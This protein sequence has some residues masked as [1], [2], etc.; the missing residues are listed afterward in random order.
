MNISHLYRDGDSRWLI[1]TNEEH[2]AG[3]ASLCSKFASEIG[4]AEIGKTMGLLHDKGKEQ[5]EWQEYIK[6]TSGYSE[7]PKATRVPHAYVGALIAY[8][9][10]GQDLSNISM[11]ILGHH[12]GLP[13]WGEYLETMHKEMP[14]GIDIPILS[15]EAIKK[16]IKAL[17]S[18]GMRE[19]DINHWFRILFSCLVDADRLDTEK[20]MNPNKSSRR[21]SGYSMKGMKVMLDEYLEN[22]RNT[23]SQT[24]LNKIR[25]EIQKHCFRASNGVPGFY[26]LTVPTGGGKTISSIAWAVNHALKHGKKRIIIAIP[27]TSIIVQT[28]EVLRKIFGN[29]NVLEH[30]SNDT[31]EGNGDS[32][33]EEQSRLATENWDYPIVVTTNVQLFE[34]M[35]SNKPS[36]CRKLH[37]LCNS[38]LILDEVQTLPIEYLNPIVESLASYQRMFG[39]SVLF[40]TA[41]MPVL[42]EPYKLSNG[43]TL[44]ALNINEIIPEGMNLHEQLKRTTIHFNDE[45]KTAEEIAKE[46]SK[47]ERVLCIVNTRK[48]AQEIFQHLPDEGLKLHLSRMMCPSHISKT[49]NDIKDALRNPEKKV[50]RVISTQLIE[51]GVDIDFPIVFREEI[52]LDSVLQAAG[53]CNREGKAKNGDVYV[54][55]MGKV[56]RGYMSHSNNA[57]KSI[58]INYNDWFAPETMREYF[59]Q[60]YCRSLSFDEKGIDAMLNKVGAEFK[61]A[62]EEF[63]LIED[64]GYKIVVN[65]DKFETA[66]L[67]SDLKKNGP[68]YS[69]IKR[70]S[71]YTV[72]IHEQDFIEMEKMGLLEQLTEDLYYAY[73]TAQYDS[74]IGLKIGNHWLEEILI[75]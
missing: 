11:P 24:T 12:S 43:E 16:E 27:Y 48:K 26:S 60:F 37:N 40:T 21:T 31:E 63:K 23:S 34:S 72:S 4:C 22:L 42:D 62:A 10:L 7:G 41:S 13:D 28:A 56:P 68:T 2:C 73:D 6:S 15:D 47:Y 59:H 17:A 45:N 19:K 38:V 75:K 67:I 66:N 54:F 50:I 33:R 29:D 14:E 53:R 64:N 71:L 51:A 9:V 52:G 46:I 44:N 74:K 57:R 20:F 61:T 1:Q 36:K 58:P 32:Q 8:K 49:I 3:V 55:S 5:P 65:Y 69:L 30:H 39:L 70:L 25:A 35:F 18:K